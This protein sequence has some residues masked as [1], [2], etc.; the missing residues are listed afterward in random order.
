MTDALNF[1][2]CSSLLVL[3]SLDDIRYKK[4]K[5]VYPLIWGCV[6]FAV[7]AWAGELFPA[8]AG[9]LPGMAL[10][11]LS[12]MTNGAVGMGD[13]LIAVSIGIFTGLW[14]S[15]LLLF[16][17]MAAAAVVGCG[18]IGAGRW[19]RKKKI[20]FVPFLWLAYRGVMI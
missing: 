20:P 3:C 6:G 10:L 13:G 8:A 15:L 11:G 19:G 18:M 12:W 1:I 4:I 14:G 9:C 5:A 17:A 16:W 2:M 7:R